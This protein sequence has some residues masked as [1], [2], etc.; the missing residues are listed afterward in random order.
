MIMRHSR[1][2]TGLSAICACLLVA[3]VLGNQTMLY[4]ASTINQALGIQTSFVEN[5]EGTNAAELTYFPS[6]YGELNADDPGFR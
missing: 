6:E 2:W 5:P 1:L 3:A 4:Y